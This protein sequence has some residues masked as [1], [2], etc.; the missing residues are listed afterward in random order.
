[1]PGSILFSKL[2]G[3]QATLNVYAVIV[4]LVYSWTLYASFWKVPSWLFFLNA[5][6]ILSIYAYSFVVDWVE[7][8]LLLSGVILINFL[9]PSLWWKEKFLARSISFI[10]IFLGSIILRLHL[11][12]DPDLR[13]EFVLTQKTWWL[14]TSLILGFGIW[15]LP[16]MTVWVRAL[17]AFADRCLIFLYIYLP[18]SIVSIVVIIVRI[19]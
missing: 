12:R 3:R 13:E 16:K 15:L 9:L 5:G 1:M 8:V 11:Y 17:E 10:I 19:I 14:F 7:S 4:F 6:Q 2:P 18:L